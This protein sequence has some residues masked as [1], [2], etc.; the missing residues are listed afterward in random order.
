MEPA[1]EHR[2]PAAGT[3]SFFLPSKLLS[4]RLIWNLREWSLT[5]TELQLKQGMGAASLST[6]P[7]GRKATNTDIAPRPSRGGGSSR[8]SPGEG[9]GLWG[10][11]AEG[12]SS[13]HPPICGPFKSSPPLGSSN[14]SVLPW[15]ISMAMT[16]IREGGDAGGRMLRAGAGVSPA[17]FSCSKGLA[18]GRREGSG[19]GQTAP[20]GSSQA[21][22][23]SSPCVCMRVCLC[24]RV[25]AYPISP[26]S[27]CG[28][29]WEQTADSHSFLL[30]PGWE[31]SLN[32]WREQ[33]RCRLPAEWCGW[34]SRSSRCS[35]Y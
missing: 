25:R 13:G 24:V 32:Y 33:W 1:P 34:R 21:H 12:H 15:Q 11:E 16:L 3:G 9:G 23:V 26:T 22:G 10:V 17:R 8:L 18:H 20:W 29:R 14:F 28:A 27:L 7:L 5:H 35:A 6:I 2:T 31:E 30:I 19:T 4:F